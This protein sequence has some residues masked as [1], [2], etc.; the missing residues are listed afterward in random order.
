MTLMKLPTDGSGGANNCNDGSGGTADCHDNAFSFS[1]CVRTTPA[2]GGSPNQEVKITMA[3]SISGD[4][5]FYEDSTIYVDA[6]SYPT[7]CTSAP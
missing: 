6:S 4:Q 3:S 1:C 7:L 2:G 5:V